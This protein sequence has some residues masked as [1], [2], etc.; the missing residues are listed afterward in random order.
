MRGNTRGDRGRNSH[1]GPTPTP[2]R[3]PA[4]WLAPPTVAWRGRFALIALQHERYRLFLF[5]NKNANVARH[6]RML[7]Y[8]LAIH[9]HEG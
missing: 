4:G 9:P 6:V 7:G 3:T 8:Y 5:R 1:D 2:N